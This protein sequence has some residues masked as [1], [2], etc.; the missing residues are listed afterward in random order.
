[1]VRKQSGTASPRLCQKSRGFFGAYYQEGGLMMFKTLIKDIQAVRE[2]DP[3]VRNIVEVLLAYPGLHALEM[4]RVAH[5]FFRI[6][7]KLFARIIS[8]LTRFF[9]GIEI[10]P[11]AQIGKGVFIDH[12]M[13]VVI[14]ETT[15]IKDYVTLY[16]GVVLGGTGKEKGKR[17]PTVEKGVVVAAGAMVLGSIV[18]GENARVG[19]GAVV[20]KNVPPNCTVVGVPAKVVVQDGERINKLDHG[21]MPDPCV[22]R[23][24]KMNNQIKTLEQRVS[25]LESLL[26]KQQNIS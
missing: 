8:H 1:M 7:F 18:I 6:H 15:I 23:V 16:Q 22:Q 21:N 2:R 26:A 5:F 19:A 3:A 9:T 14:G 25:Q 13:G 4:H 12:G 17:H 11:G 10:H 24:T 20:L